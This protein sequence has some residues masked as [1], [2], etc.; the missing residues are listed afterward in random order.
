[1]QLG[2]FAGIALAA[3]LLGSIP[4]GYLIARGRG[5]DI[6][7]VGSGNIGATNVLRTLGKPAGITV[8]ALDAL[9]GFVAT[10]FVPHLFMQAPGAGEAITA[11]ICSILGH[12]YT[13][14]LKFKGGKGIA[15]SAG[16]LV[17]LVPVGILVAF[18]AWVVTFL[19]SGYVSLASI[20]AAL[21]LPPAVLF[22]TPSRAL[23]VTCTILSA[24][25]IYKHRGNI[26]RLRNGTEHRFKR[27]AKKSD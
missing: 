21:I 26:E 24:L 1:M 16:A 23:L 13:L 4:T 25:A 14:W 19:L 9:K 27:G 20:V 12:N 17:A 18:I 3:Y 6:R 10:M 15:T 5:I 22:T 2:P 7:K 8:L 11:A